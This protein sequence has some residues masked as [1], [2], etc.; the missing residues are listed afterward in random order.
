MIWT[1]SHIIWHGCY[2]IICHL[3]TSDT[4]HIHIHHPLTW[5]ILIIGQPND[6]CPGLPC[7]Y[8]VKMIL[9]SHSGILLLSW[10]SFFKKK[11]RNIY[12]RA[13]SNHQIHVNLDATIYPGLATLTQNFNLRNE[14][15]HLIF[16]GQWIKYKLSQKTELIPQV[17]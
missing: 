4:N 16:S 9:T 3:T 7:L 17:T 1:S 6:N 8:L 15:L 12:V 13:P 14:K 2:Y 5:F 10:Q 11:S